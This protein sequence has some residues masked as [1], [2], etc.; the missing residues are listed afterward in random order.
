MYEQIFSLQAKTLKAL[1]HARRLEIVQ[2]L[3]DQEL[4]VTAIHEML[5][6]PQANVS[7][8]LI[9]LKDAGVLKTRKSGKQIYY[10][11]AS[12]MFFKALDC[13]RAF[14]IE[15]YRDTELADEFT[16]QMNELVPVT[17]DPV[18]QMR[19]S[20]KTASF[21]YKYNG[22]EYYFCASGCLKSFRENPSIFINKET[23]FWTD[24]PG[25][26]T[27]LWW[28]TIDMSSNKET[29]NFKISGMH[30]ASCASN[31]QRK[32]NK[33][34]GVDSAEVSYASEE[35]CVVF[36]P[37]MTK[38]SDLKRAV[39]SLGYTAHLDDGIHDTMPARSHV[40]RDRSLKQLKIKLFISA[41]LTTPMMVAMLPGM[42]MW[43]MD[44]RLHLILATP[45]QFWIGRDYY[46][47]A[48]RALKN[49]M[50]NMDTL[51]VLGTSVA[52]FFS[53]VVVLFGRQLHTLGVEAHAYFETSAA[54]ITLILLGKFLEARAKGKTSDAIKK[55]LD[56]QAK[57]AR[58]IREGKAI[59]IPLEEVN[60]GDVIKV[61]PGEKI[62]VDGLI[63]KGT[64]AIDE[65]M[66]S[67]E[68]V[69]V[70]KTMGDAVVGATL[71]TN[72]N[73]VIKAT[74]V[75]ADTFLAHVVDLVKKAQGSKAPIQKLVDKVSSVFVPTVIVLSIISFGLWWLLG[76]DPVLIHA[77]LAMI[78]VLII[79]C[80]CALGLATPVSIMVGVGKGAEEGILIKDAENLEVAGK[81]SMIVFDK[82][83]TLT[84]GKPELQKLIFSDA[85]KNKEEVEQLI[86]SLEVES[87]HPLAEAVVK[88][89]S[90]KHEI[91]NVHD[92]K[93]VA[94]KG[95]KG[96]ISDHEVLIGTKTFLE[97]HTIELDQKLLGQ[98][99]ALASQ[100][101]TTSY[102][103]VDGKHTVVLGIA[104]TVKKPSK[105]VIKQLRE[106][107]IKSVMLT[108]D[109]QKTAEAVAKQIGIDQVK[110]EVLPK[111]KQDVIN[112]LKKNGEVVAMIGDGINDAPALAS[113]DIGIAMGLGT[114]VAI[115]TA[116][117]T[118]LRSD[119]RLVPKAV[120]LS[121]ATLQNIQQN[122]FWAFAYNTIL[123][124]VAMGALYPFFQIQLNPVLA[125]AAMALSSV[126]VVTNALRLKGVNLWIGGPFS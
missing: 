12:P 15:Q 83:G 47:S 20:P 97:E 65:S 7:Q 39:E 19:V 72:G 48:W 90:K 25:I 42:P 24:A 113:A 77:L 51:I 106:L 17:H 26:K 125:S 32:L 14:L 2:L 94:G 105:A 87:H 70:T 33:V 112:E 41:I 80:P 102:V 108:G 121:K 49:G 118:L 22:Q 59:E 79:A 45:V 84:E 36:D 60:V 124:P 40:S 62:P 126:S 52:Y 11:V 85:V 91:K 61:K 30:C 21:A 38:T 88:K 63:E 75:G 6:L 37:K 35:A 58:V 69:P 68:S 73:L 8:H 109:N 93:D 67:G 104:D 44:P 4:P 99:Q 31:S 101:Q 82:T 81:I 96:T 117:V 92:F 13:L 55:L 89:L 107:G 111:D 18:C 95:V 54:I 100:A 64:A 114:D 120:K 122:L 1:A 27:R 29:L 115:E 9:V 98:A 86:L 76:P 123:I 10:K 57:K 23:Q 78:G 43:L 46:L 28:H 3:Q 74:R 116:G 16:L 119:I 5:D 34:V 50:T 66:V 53:L 110:A 56:L 103:A 71:N